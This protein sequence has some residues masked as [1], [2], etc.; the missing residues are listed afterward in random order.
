MKFS[1]GA[2]LRFGR[3]K[4][5]K[6]TVQLLGVGGVFGIL[7][8]FIGAPAKYW[9]GGIGTLALAAG[10]VVLLTGTIAER[11]EWQAAHKMDTK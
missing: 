2:E 1:N 10:L 7:S 11:K 6:L 3:A 8:W 5:S 4:Y 9:V